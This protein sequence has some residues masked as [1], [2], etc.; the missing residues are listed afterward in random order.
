MWLCLSCIERRSA[1]RSIVSAKRTRSLE[2]DVNSCFFG[3]H[4]DDLSSL[5][6]RL[7]WRCSWLSYLKFCWVQPGLH[8]KVIHTL[9]KVKREP[10]RLKSHPVIKFLMQG[11]Q[12]TAALLGQ[13]EIVVQIC[14][15]SRAFYHNQ[16][17]PM[18]SYPRNH[19]HYQVLSLRVLWCRIYQERSQLFQ[20]VER[21]CLWKMR[22][23]TAALWVQSRLQVQSVP[24]DSYA[25]ISLLSIKCQ[26]AT[27]WTT[28]HRKNAVEFFLCVA[29][30]RKASMLQWCWGTAAQ[31]TRIM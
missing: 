18:K 1:A 15:L 12:S 8:K 31:M 4:S 19:M 30:L 14:Q 5:T 22:K 9:V 17:A 10:A 13:T 20:W 29:T 24:I 23:A 26:S 27:F 16:T 21:I 3:A 7:L 25:E 6:Y 11:I 2:G 28:F